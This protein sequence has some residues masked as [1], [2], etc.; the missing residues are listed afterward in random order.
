MD[1][2]RELP[3]PYLFGEAISLHVAE[4]L[5][6]GLDLGAELTN[7]VILI[8]TEDVTSRFSFVRIFSYNVLAVTRR[9]VR[10][11]PILWTATEPRKK[12]I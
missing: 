1:D 11:A 4:Q 5:V 9:C 3:G 12:Q 8:A 6:C 2:T 10:P 7:T